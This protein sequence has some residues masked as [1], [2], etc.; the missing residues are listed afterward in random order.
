MQDVTIARDLERLDEKLADLDELAPAG[1]NGEP[2]AL[3][4]SRMKDWSKPRHG[5]PR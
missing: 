2:R 4:Q 3:R 1:L 5:R